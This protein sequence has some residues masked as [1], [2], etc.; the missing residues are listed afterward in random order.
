MPKMTKP[1]NWLEIACLA[2]PMSDRIQVRFNSLLPSYVCSACAFNAHLSKQTSFL[3]SAN[4]T[5]L[6]HCNLN[7]NWKWKHLTLFHG[8]GAVMGPDS[9]ERIPKAAVSWSSG[10]D[11]AYALFRT[12]QSGNYE[13]AALLTTVTST[14]DRIS[15]HG[16]RRALLG[17]QSRAIGIPLMEVEIPPGCDNATY[18]KRMIEATDRMKTEGIEYIIFGDIFLQDVREY[19]EKNLKGTSIT[20]VFPLWGENTHDLAKKI[21][22]SGVEAVIVCLD[23]SKIDR[24]FGG[25]SFDTGFLDSIPEEV[26]PC[27]ENGE[28]HT[29]VHN[30]PFFTKNIP[31]AIGEKVERDGFLF[32]DLYLP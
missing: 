18:E 1:N 32:T 3:Y 5:D 28:F 14:Y 26:D 8:L 15:M 4:Q 23:P 2:G 17:E 22:G 31:V 27:G 13:V 7:E 21:I 11:S 12:I 29:F 30:A 16:V 19:R 24:K 20:P 10:K 9:Q 6:L 25:N